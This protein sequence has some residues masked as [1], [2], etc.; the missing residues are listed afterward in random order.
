[1]INYD[2]LTTVRRIGRDPSLFQE[3]L[4]KVIQPNWKQGPWVAGGSI[5]RLFSGQDPLGSDIDVFFASQ[6]QYM[7]FILRIEREAKVLKKEI[8]PHNTTLQIEWQP[9]SGSTIDPASA[10]TLTIQAIHIDFFTDPA[11]VIDFFDFTICQYITDGE[12]LMVGPYTLYDTARKRL[13][14]HN[15]HHAVST[16]RRLLKYGNQGFYACGGT[17]ADL[18]QRVAADPNVINEEVISID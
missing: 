18:L 5:R 7:E 9:W 15:V 14:L 10:L 1:M 2:F 3:V 16:T 8:R 4:E 17:I 13:V 12:T 6:E 11:S